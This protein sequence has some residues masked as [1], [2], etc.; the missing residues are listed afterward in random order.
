[1]D[2]GLPL[3]DRLRALALL[4][5]E[6]EAAQ[7]AV[8]GLMAT[9]TV[10]GGVSGAGQR[11]GVLASLPPTAP[12]APAAG[13]A[14]RVSPSEKPPK[15]PLDPKPK[16][17]GA[18]RHLLATEALALPPQAW[19]AAPTGLGSA[20]VLPVAV[21]L[22]AMPVIAARRARA[23]LG[24]LAQARTMGVTI[25]LAALLHSMANGHAVR[26]LPCLPVWSVRRG[27]QLLVDVGGG[28]DPLADD[29]QQVGEWLTRVVGRSRLQR[30]DFAGTPLRGCGPGARGS[31]RRWRPPPAGVPVILLS[32]LSVIYRDFDSDWAPL[33]EWRHFVRTAAE[34][35]C[36]LLAL[37]PFPPQRVSARLRQGISLLPWSEWLDAGHVQRV[38]R[39]ARQRR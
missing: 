10:A 38:L 34:A 35:G 29:V 19:P 9:R 14:D 26:A 31:W 15:L 16:P 36:P 7:R 32:D 17:A 13:G 23:V 28:L 24:P 5:P 33:A 12:A 27:A 22:P 30:L 4:A 21:A 18:A 6:N 39:D 1:M 3:A 2:I 37:T 25:D 8:M 20:P 11:A